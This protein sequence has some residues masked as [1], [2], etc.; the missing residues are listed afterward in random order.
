M[1]VPSCDRG[2][3]RLMSH[4]L[5]YGAVK[6]KVGDRRCGIPA[7][8]FDELISSGRHLTQ[9]NKYFIKD[10]LPERTPDEIRHELLRLRGRWNRVIE[11]KIIEAGLRDLAIISESEKKI[12]GTLCFS[13]KGKLKFRF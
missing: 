2:F 5:M 12:A 7:V 3:T 8:S 4:R 1:S 6:M 10:R 9:L 13:R 11:V